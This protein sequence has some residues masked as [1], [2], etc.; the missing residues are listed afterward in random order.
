MNKDSIPKDLDVFIS[1]LG[2]IDMIKTQVIALDKSTHIALSQD[3][4][5]TIL[6]NSRCFNILKLI[7]TLNA[8][9]SFLNAAFLNSAELITEGLDGK[10]KKT[11]SWV[12]DIADG[13]KKIEEENER[14]EEENDNEEINKDENLNKNKVINNMLEYFKERFEKNE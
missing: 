7:E 8:D 13:R 6:G 11:S 2:E 4:V 1:L 9:I 10:E 3:E 12:E 5:S 14:K